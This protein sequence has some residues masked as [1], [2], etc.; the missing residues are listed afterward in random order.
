M[1]KVTLALLVVTSILA[2]C[3]T[4]CC[5]PYGYG[6]YYRPAVVVRTVPAYT[7]QTY[8]TPMYATPVYA[9]PAYYQPVYATPAPVVTWWNTCC[10]Y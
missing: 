2:G 9:A 5:T 7:V 4:D 3:A 1:R 8:A 6:Y 10:V